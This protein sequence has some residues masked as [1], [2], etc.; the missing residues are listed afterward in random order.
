MA[1]LTDPNALRHDITC[2][3]STPVCA[4]CHKQ[5]HEIPDVV[6]AAEAE[7]MTPETWVRTQ[8]GTYNPANEHFLCTEDFIAEEERR[9][10]V[11]LAGPDGQR[12]VCP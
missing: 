3:H 11:R 1:E 8:E 2:N 9:G 7:G 10:G 5:A 6:M 4:L 12:W